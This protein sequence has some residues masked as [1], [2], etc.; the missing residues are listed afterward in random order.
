[1]NKK[2]IKKNLY[3][4]LD[5]LDIPLFTYDRNR[6]T[7]STAASVVEYPL[8][9]IEYNGNKITRKVIIKN[10]N[11]LLTEFD[12]DVFNSLIYLASKE[13]VKDNVF[14]EK[15]TFNIK[16]ICDFLNISHGG[17]NNER[18]KNSI[19]RIADTTLNYLGKTKEENKLRKYI[20][21]N[22]DIISTCGFRGE[23][24]DD[25]TIVNNNFVIFNKLIVNNINNNYFCVINFDEYLNLETAISR[26]IYLKTRK[27]FWHLNNIGV[28]KYKKDYIDF[29]NLLLIKPQNYL[30]KVKNQ[31][32]KH[33]NELKSKNI[34]SDWEINKSVQTE[35]FVL[36]L[37]LPKQEIKSKNRSKEIT[38]EITNKIEKFIELYPEQYNI[39]IEEAQSKAKQQVGGKEGLFYES[40]VK[41]F[42]NEM[43]DNFTLSLTEN[44]S[45][46]F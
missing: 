46:N 29:C 12:S 37:Y 38:E 9:P 35:N 43:I 41:V 25:N 20:D 39:F 14:P 40:A 36:T 42:L 7:S 11:G 2:E 44:K 31:L 19:K 45:P 18:I 3:Y 10:P 32:E 16:N 17:R 4:E 15:L 30:S 24:Y 28:N 1:M 6:K 26:A 5:V 8:K 22:F 13:Y 27:P 33:L 23:I 21:I 34:I